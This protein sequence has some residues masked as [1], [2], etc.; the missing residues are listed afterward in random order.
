MLSDRAIRTTFIISLLGHGLFLSVIPFDIKSPKLERPK[1]FTLQIEIEKPAPLPK[2]ERM[3]EK[4]K[5]KEVIEKPKPK[6]EREVKEIALQEISLQ[7]VKEKIEVLNPADEAMLRYQDIVKQRIEEVRKYPVWAKEQ[8]LEGIIRL[9]FTISSDGHSQ[10]VRLV[11]SSGS[12]I[13]EREA[14]DTIE[15][16]SPFPSPPKEIAASSIQMEVRLV[17]TLQ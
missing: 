6:S 14:I 11:H 4:K 2:V 10:E 8:G 12:K 16:A 15:R 3:G 13:L 7:P 17:F 5:I 1:E 9:K